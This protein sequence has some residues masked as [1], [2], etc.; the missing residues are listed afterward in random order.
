MKL[1]GVAL[2][3][4]T[5]CAKLLGLDET[6]F[7]QRDAPSDSP[8]AC[9]GVA[10]ACVAATG[11]TICGQLRGT[12]ATAGLPLRVAAPTGAACDAAN[13]EGPCAFTASARTT[14]DFFAGAPGVP[15][16]G[17]VDDCGRF[18]IPDPG[19]S[20]PDV[21][22]IFTATG[23]QLAATLVLGRPATS[24]VDTLDAFP[25]STAT[26]TAWSMQIGADASTGYLAR[27]TAD[28]LPLAGD[29]VAH[30]GSSALANPP[31]TLPWAG[32]FSD[33][34]GT[35]DRTL[36][37]TAAPGLAFALISATDPFELDGFRLGRR[38]RVMGLK[39]VPNALIY[40]VVTNC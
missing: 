35:L 11:R 33:E 40:V 25:V 34:L 17:I 29:Q 16:M 3:V 39:Q 18:A 24:G 13:T 4:T 2:L 22:A 9:D 38:C 5:G 10:A 20:G 37:A 8:S 12:G 6:K 36:T 31:G 15:A 7:D 28:M 32:Y 21:A 26:A 19:A 14:A 27:Y 23:Y 1:L 30:D